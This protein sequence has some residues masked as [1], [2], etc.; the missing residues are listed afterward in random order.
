MN[1]PTNMQEP[2]QQMRYRP[3]L[4]FYHPKPTGAGSALKLELHPAHD[5]TDGSI[6]AT[7]APQI[8][9]ANFSAP[10]PIY[11]RFGWENA[12]VT[13]L[14][15]SDL[16]QML[17]VFRGETES[18][19]DG[20]GLIHKT[21]RAT[22]RILLR[23]VCDMKDGYSLEFYRTTADHTESSAYIFLTR[24]EAVGLVAAIESS[25]GVI[26]FGIPTVLQRDTSAY[27]AAQREIRN[28]PA[29]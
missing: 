18:I 24:N 23:H 12:I 6:W 9:K 19:E 29:A 21:A 8:S 7:I 28:A 14:D 26:C 4:A 2:M 13:K 17:M 16:T 20:M 22:T 27:R 15:F 11:A 25:F 3:S 10:T 5:Q 1:T